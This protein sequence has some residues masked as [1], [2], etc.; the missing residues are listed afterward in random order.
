MWKKQANCITHYV[1]QQVCKCCP[2]V[3]RYYKLQTRPRNLQEFERGIIILI[4]K[5]N[6]KWRN[7]SL[8]AAILWVHSNKFFKNSWL[9]VS[10]L[11]RYNITYPFITLTLLIHLRLSRIYLFSTPYSFS[12]IFPFAPQFPTKFPILMHPMSIEKEK[13]KE[14]K[15]NLVHLPPSRNDQQL[16]SIA[17][18]YE[19]A[20]ATW[21]V[22]PRGREIAL[23][24]G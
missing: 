3:E 7:V 1:L 11:K 10:I 23:T 19:V 8:A 21:L 9:D 22:Y 13:R 5:R 16:I 12:L 20:D 15:K 4:H 6:K 14:K 18:N 2:N 24:S 17:A